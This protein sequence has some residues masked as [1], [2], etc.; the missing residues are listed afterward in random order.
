MSSSSQTTSSMR[1]SVDS[2]DPSYGTSTDLDPAGVS[3]AEVAIEVECSAEQWSA[4]DVDPAMAATEV[5]FVDGVRRVDAR[6]W[7]EHDGAVEGGI[8]ASY[9]AGAIRCDGQAQ[10]DVV[11]VDHGVFSASPA[12]TS[13]ETT[14]GTF[15]VRKASASTPEVLSLA[16]QERMTELEVTVAEHAAALADLVVIDGPLKGRGHLPPAVGFVKTHHVAY[17]PPELHRMVGSLRA[18]QRTPL[19]II[20]APWSRHSWY[21]RL[22]GEAS[23]PWAGV[24]RCECSA[25]LDTAAAVALADRVSATLPRFASEAHKDA[26]AP[27]NLYPIGALERE[28]RRRLGDQKLVYRALRIAAAR[29]D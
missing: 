4:R 26:R 7:I 9:A 25:N 21:L 12:T 19:F 6:V 3:S 23:S 11:E 2:W 29:K 10:F 28:L 27:Q 22:P 14:A 24:V 18:G 15:G 5:A 16:L 13:I 20:G 1:F 17:L 8:C